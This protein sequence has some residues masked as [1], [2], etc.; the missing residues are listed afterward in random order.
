M[1][2]P[3]S[4]F[5]GL[6]TDCLLYTA[7]SPKGIFLLSRAIPLVLAS[8]SP[9]RRQLL[10]L[11]G[12][13]FRVQPALVNE[14]PNPAEAPRA[15]VLR[16]AESK[17][18]AGASGAQPGELVIGSD[19]IVV[20]PA[21]L[22]LG[23]ICPAEILGKPA[24]AL[25][26]THML[27]RLRGRFHQVMTAVAVYQPAS[28]Q[29]VSELCCT[30]VKMR[31]Y[32]DAEI[33]AYVSS[34]DPLDKAGAYAIQHAEFDPVE[35]LL[36]CFANVVG[37]PLC[38]LNRSLAVFGLKAPLETPQEYNHETCPFCQRIMHENM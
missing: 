13:Q 19:T 5:T 4:S 22:D 36:G 6:L 29:L 17:A 9:R 12:W 31:N 14:M 7:H 15:Y 11:G 2:N 27:R 38:L 18:R 21:G 35:S 8:N 10:E 23:E 26:A 33:A 30:S 24:G 34:G 37:L 20:D 25:E 16:M 32:S 1:P 28:G 3:F